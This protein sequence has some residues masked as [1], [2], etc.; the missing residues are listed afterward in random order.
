MMGARVSG[1]ALAPEGQPNLWTL[2]STEGIRSHVGDVS[3]RNALQEAISQDEPEVVLHLAAQSLVRRSYRQPIETF[4]TNVLGL[5]KLLDVVSKSASVRAF[6]NVTSDKC[7][8]NVEQLWGYRETDPMGGRDPYSAS[9]GCAELV[10]S[11]MR[12]S[13]FAPY[14]EGK[15]ICRIASGRA[16]NVIGGG[17]W[18]E[19]RLV[20]DI[21]RGCLGS[22]GSVTIR[23]PGSMRPWQHVLEPLRGYLMLAEKLVEGTPGADEGWNFGPDRR[24][25]RPVIEV[26]NAIVSALGK[27][28]IDVARQQPELHEA[29][30]LRLDSTKARQIG[31]EPRLSFED[32]VEMTATWYGKWSSGA[33]PSALCEDQINYYMALCNRTARHD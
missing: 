5:V 11:S 30:M 6:V 1:F 31:W 15:S 22:A 2:L 4:E 32:T 8:E 27:G 26:A 12:N 13:F 16:G 33:D 3:D 14:A 29:K 7:Y 10:T 19:D 17:D 18:S 20:P 28:R 23:A 24:D 21:V 9:K 25:E